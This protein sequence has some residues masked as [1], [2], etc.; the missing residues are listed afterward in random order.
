MEETAGIQKN[1]S[2]AAI[3]I[4]AFLC[5]F[6]L[7]SGLLSMFFLVPFG[8]ALLACNSFRFTICVTVVLNI[9][10]SVFIRLFIYNKFD[11][12]FTDIIYYTTLLLG[13]A[14][15]IAGS[16]FYNIRTVY[17]FILAS[18]A[19]ALVFLFLFFTGMNKSVFSGIFDDLAEK[20]SLILSS[21]ENGAAGHSYL[22]QMLTPE[23]IFEIFENVMLHGGALLTVSFFFFIN[24]QLAI[25]A[26]WLFKK[27]R[28]DPG[29]SAFFAPPNTIWVLSC[30]LATI[31]LSKM[32]RIEITEIA[33]WNVFVVCAIIFLAQGAGILT[34]ILARRTGIFRF[35]TNVLII[36]MILSPGLNTIA[37][38]AL[39]LL[40]VMENWLPFR[41]VKKG[42]ASTPEP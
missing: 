40:G 2:I 5:V 4:C 18:A 14:W 38:A 27:Q 8:F 24:R 20:F 37:V 29:L 26:L 34:H 19:G 33:A 7:N 10:V 39:L 41:A 28:K 3:L 31:M 22:Q 11:L 25:T 12:L 23:G 21:P 13:F 42:T 9:A 17:R 32:F 35:A 1:S 6:F 16:K 15:I 36:L 30:S